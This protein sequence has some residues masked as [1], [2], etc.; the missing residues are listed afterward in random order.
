MSL[1]RRRIVN[2]KIP[3]AETDLGLVSDQ[4]PGCQLQV[5]QGLRIP[6]A[7]GLGVRWTP[8]NSSIFHHSNHLETRVTVAQ[9]L[10]A[11]FR[12]FLKL[13]FCFNSCTWFRKFRGKIHVLG[14]RTSRKLW[15]A[16]AFERIF[17]DSLWI[18]W[19]LISSP[20]LTAPTACF[21][22]NHPN[23]PTWAYGCAERR[24]FSCLSS[25]VCFLRSL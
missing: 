13:P 19:N 16:V 15:T 21:K 1:L 12:C 18:F 2:E 10:P 11:T 5:G 8:V 24:F 14:P 3:G 4:G 17:P 23:R 25:E 6:A 9:W 22:A 20:G 7:Q